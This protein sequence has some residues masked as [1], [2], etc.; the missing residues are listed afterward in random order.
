[1]RIFVKVWKILHRQE[2]PTTDRP[3]PRPQTRRVAF[4]THS[5]FKTYSHIY[6]V[7]LFLSP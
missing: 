1:M 2:T 4:L 3:A 6:I 7:N 5:S